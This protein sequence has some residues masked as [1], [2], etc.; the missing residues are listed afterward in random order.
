MKNTILSLLFL[1]TINCVSAQVDLSSLNTPIELIN[2]ASL[3]IKA[4]NY[5]QA[6]PKLKS[7]PNF[8]ILASN[9]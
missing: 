3:D 4:G 2:S 1:L 5:S 7:V 6:I 8:L 9:E